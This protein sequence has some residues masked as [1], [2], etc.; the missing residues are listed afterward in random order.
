MIF[1]LLIPTTFLALAAHECGHCLMAHVFRVAVLRVHLGVG[2]QVFRTRLGSLDLSFSILPFGASTAYG[3]IPACGA[4]RSIAAAGPAANCVIAVV[5]FA[6][7]GTRVGGTAVD[8]SPAL[9][10]LW[11]TSC[12]MMSTIS[13]AL[14]AFNLLPVRPLDGAAIVRG[15]IEANKT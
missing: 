7:S 2:P 3:E 11:A 4:T 14:A 9:E 1:L 10:S 8:L 12:L 15:R 5:A 13:A 6:M